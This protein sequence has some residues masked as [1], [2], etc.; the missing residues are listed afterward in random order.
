MLHGGAHFGEGFYGDKTGAR[1]D[2][3]IAGRHAHAIPLFFRGILVGKKKYFLGHVAVRIRG[4]AF[5]GQDHEG[6]AFFVVPGE[7][8]KI[9]LLSEDVSLG[10]FFAA[11]V[12]PEDDGGVGLR[13]KFGA[14]LGVDAVGFAF[15]ALLRQRGGRRGHQ[16]QDQR[17]GNIANGLRAEKTQT[18]TSFRAMRTAGIV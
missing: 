6:G 8:V 16:D 14:P 5:R 7:V 17:G 11:G 15:A 13:G 9:F 10:R 18:F 3:G 4:G 1:L 12:A 2:A